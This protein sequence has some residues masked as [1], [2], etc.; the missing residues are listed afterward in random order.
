MGRVAGARVLGRTSPELYWWDG[1]AAAGPA[2]LAMSREQ[3][4][5]W[6]VPSSKS[7]TQTATSS[8]AS[9]EKSPFAHAIFIRCI[10]KQPAVV[11]RALAGGA[12]TLR[13]QLPSGFSTKLGPGD[14]VELIAGHA[15]FALQGGAGKTLELWSGTTTAAASSHTLHASGASSP[16]GPASPK[17]PVGSPFDTTLRT[18]VEAA[19]AHGRDV[20]CASQ[21]S[22]VNDA[23]VQGSDGL[24]VDFDEYC[25]DADPSPPRVLTPPVAAERADSLPPK[26]SRLEGE[27]WPTI[28][29][30]PRDAAAAS[31]PTRCSTPPASLDQASAAGT[32]LASQQH[33]AAVGSQLERNVAVHEIG[34][35]GSVSSSCASASDVTASVVGGLDT[36]GS[37]DDVIATALNTGNAFRTHLSAFVPP[38]SAHGTPS[39]AA[40]YAQP[41]PA[42][43]SAANST[44]IGFGWKQRRAANPLGDATNTFGPLGASAAESQVVYF[45]HERH[46][47][48]V[49]AS[50]T[51][52]RQRRR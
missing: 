36:Q 52:P 33:K 13:Q 40:N 7:A 44:T 5:V 47:P 6:A 10:G 37:L 49:A 51:T 26:R 48:I 27:S 11:V 38:A 15:A 29:M 12:R 19:R 30:E 25:H 39:Q 41:S 18:L 16:R 32:Q 31:C 20:R 42:A 23:V 9:H 17:S 24:V 3:L 50:G 2:A 28:E 1:G 8:S 22:I 21:V 43:S 35:G 4:E 45:D 34:R 46:R 14:V